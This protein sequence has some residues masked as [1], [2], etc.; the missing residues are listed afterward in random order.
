MSY[1]TLFVLADP[2]EPQLAAL[3]QLADLTTVIGKSVDVFASRAAQATV[4]FNWSGSLEL[5]KQVFGMCSNLRWVHSRSVGLERVLFSELI[6]SPVPL[7]N[8][9]G[10]FSAAL[11]EF[12]LAAMLHF[13]KDFPRL[14][15][16]QRAGVWEEFDVLLL[17]GHT[18]GIVGYGDIGR[19]VASRARAMGMTVLGLKR[20]VSTAD[21]KDSFVEQIYS[22]EQRRVMI[23][24]CDYLVVAAP[25]TAETRGMIGEAEFA[26]MKPT[27]VVIN[28][29]R[30]PI[31]EEAA[32]IRAL[33][34]GQIKGA[35]LDVFDREPLPAGHPFYKLENVLLSPHCA[36]HTPDWIDNAMRFFIEQFR[37]FQNGESLVNVV[38]KK[39][40]Y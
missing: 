39:L 26:A 7:T 28:V 31:I 14:I 34:T 24:R 9:V 3:Q 36:D 33:S 10:V 40:G 5:F 37:R 16:A 19:A 38:D 32:L 20:R 13:A 15:R 4:L 2:S 23:A 22:P 11:G 27:A 30:G 6:E 12:A 18:V 35:A 1:D 25:L 29:G 8:G 17:A 21:V